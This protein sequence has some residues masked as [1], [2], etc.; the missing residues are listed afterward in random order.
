MWLKS[1]YTYIIWAS[2]LSIFSFFPISG[3]AAEAPTPNTEIIIEVA[4]DGSEPFDRFVFNPFGPRFDLLV[5]GLGGH[6]PGLDTQNGD[7]SIIPELNG[8]VRTFDS[9][10]YNVHWNVNDV[11]SADPNNDGVNGIASNVVIRISTGR[12]NVSWQAIPGRCKTSGVAPVSSIVDNGATGDLLTCN[13]GDVA[14]GTAGTISLIAD[15]V[16]R[17]DGARSDGGLIP[18]SATIDTDQSA[19]VT[20]NEVTT[21]ISGVPSGDWIKSPAEYIPGVFN[22]ATAGGLLIYPL[23]F[24][25]FNPNQG[26]VR[27]TDA[28]D[29]TLPIQFFDHAWDLT[30]NA[31]LATPALNLTVGMAGPP[32]GRDLCGGYDGVGGLPYG[33]A[34]ADG[35]DNETNPFA[36]GCTIDGASGAA[37]YPIVQVDITGQNTTSS[38]TNNADGNPN[39]DKVVI[40]A[41]IAFWAPLTELQAKFNLGAGNNLLWNTIT[42]S[43]ALDTDVGGGSFVLAT[44]NIELGVGSGLNETTIVNNTVNGSVDPVSGPVLTGGSF[45]YRHTG[46]FYPGPYQEMFFPH[47]DGLERMGIDNRPTTLGGSG[48]IIDG[49]FVGPAN[50]ENYGWHGTGKVSRNEI[51]TLHARVVG[52]SDVGLPRDEPIHLCTAI[53]NSHIEIIGFPSNF[54]RLETDFPSF[55]GNTMVPSVSSSTGSASDGIAHVLLGDVTSGIGSQGIIDPFSNPWTRINQLTTPDYVVQVTDVDLAASYPLDQ[56]ELGCDDTDAGPAGWISTSGDLSAFVTGT[57]TDGNIVYGGISRIRVLMLEPRSWENDGMDANTFGSETSTIILN[58][59][60][61]VKPAIID[62]ADGDLIRIH[63]ARGQGTID[64]NN[65]VVPSANC[66]NDFIFTPGGP[67]DASWC[68]LPY[69]PANEAVAPNDLQIDARAVE[70]TFF[71]GLETIQASHSDRLVVGSADLG[72]TKTNISGSSDLISNG[73]LVTFRIETSIVGSPQEK[74]SDMFVVDRID[75][76]P[77]FE[78]VSQTDPVDA[79]GAALTNFTCTDAAGGVQDSLRCDFTSGAFNAADPNTFRTSPFFATWTITVRAIGAPGDFAIPNEAVVSADLNQLGFPPLTKTSQASAFAYTGPSYNELFIRKNVPDLSGACTDD[80]GAAEL[81]DSTLIA[82][83]CS[84]FQIN[85]QYQYEMTFE[86]KGSTDLE[87]V[88]IID[89]FPFVGDNAE[90]AAGFAGTPAGSNV[91]DGRTPES[92]F[93]GTSVLVSAVKSGGTLECTTA[94]PATINRDPALDGSAW[95]AV[96]DASS[97]GFRLTLATIPIG[98]IENL[99]MTLQTAGNVDDDIYTNNIGARTDTILVPARSND[100]SAMVQGVVSIG[101]IIWNDANAD[102]LQTA[103]ELGIADATVTLLNGDDTVYD[104]DPLTAGIQPLTILTIADGLYNF[105]DLPEGAYKVQ[106]AMPAGFI[107]TI[108]QQGADDN[109]TGNDSNIAASVGQTHT[110]GVFNLTIGGEPDGVNSSI[111]GSDD[112]DNDDDASGNMT[113]DFGFMRTVKI[114]SYVWLEVDGDGDPSNGSP[115]P[116]IG[117]VITATS[118]TTGISYSDTTDALGGYGI[119]VP[120]ND[121]YIV[122]IITPSGHTPTV[123]LGGNNVPLNDTTG[124][125]QSHMGTGAGTTVVVNTID[126]LSLD[127]GF[128]STTMPSAI[129]INSHWMLLMI[130]LGL[131]FLTYHYGDARKA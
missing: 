38:P 90:P 68:S 13:L 73:D 60:A 96:C 100:V 57:D 82:G 22:G 1:N 125:N 62:A 23:S 48:P 89:T 67:L 123:N 36:I 29:D 99:V 45:A 32:V 21:T 24:K 56:H 97:T 91:G 71:L 117:A 94:A 50:F 18:I 106:V 37:G 88:V 72:I 77:N 127:F 124:N 16:L 6:T 25:P 51:V 107:P 41:Q 63:T 108:N 17:V 31:I 12:E 110:S 26:T 54:Q 114:G 126:N 119:D 81:S 86:N 61:R 109:D 55:L 42:E 11:D 74:F 10:S 129:P 3:Q 35:I 92:V 9:V 85:G 28:F 19:L 65:V 111:A 121:S 59:Q 64:I 44:E 49:D 43:N 103:G 4:Q 33:T 8:V 15:V 87:N 52:S 104:S 115:L 95:T 47:D 69:D 14:E 40:A 112:A 130:T 128:I 105:D 83:D 53:D 30:A 122:K 101:S 102:G 131:I 34:V 58:M 66:T 98:G 46:R 76:N 27:G 7:G 118:T 75:L 39:L 79:G 120:I 5:D 78:F 70:E 84:V 113:I 2:L 93:S 80:S 20:S 116:V